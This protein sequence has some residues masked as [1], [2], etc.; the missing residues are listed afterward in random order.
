MVGMKLIDLTMETL[1]W[2]DVDTRTIG[3]HR[4]QKLLIAT[5]ELLAQM[6]QHHSLTA[7]MRPM[8]EPM[9]VKPRDW[10]TPTNGGYLSSYVRPIKL[11]K[12]TSKGYYEELSHTEMPVVYAAVN[13]MQSTAWAIN[14]PIL[15][16]LK[17]FWDRG[18]AVAGLPARMGQEI[19]SKPFD[20]ETNE[21]ARTAWR[22]AAA[23]VYQSNTEERSKR[24]NVVFTIDI[25]ER[26][27][28]YPSLYMPYQL[29]FRGRIYAVPAF[30]PQGPDHMKALLHF[31]NGKPLGANGAQW[32][33]MHGA[34]VAGNDKVS[35]EARVQWVLD[36]EQEI[37]TC[38]KNPLAERG[39]YTE[40]GGISI[41]KPWQFLAFC[42]EWAGYCV[43]GDAFVSR[44]AVALDGSC[45]G[46]Q[47][48][49]GMLRDEIGG[50]AVNLI[51]ADKPSDVYAMVADK[52]NSSLKA[53]IASG[54]SPNG[55]QEDVTFAAQWLEFGV[56]RKVTKRSVMT[57]AYGS[58]Q[59]G[60][61][62]QVLED[63]LKPAFRAHQ[64]SGLPFP[65]EGDGFKAASF[66]AAQIWE[67]V[68][69]TL[70]KSVEAMQ[71][72]QKAAVAVSDVGLPIR[73]S[74]PV[75]FPVMQAYWD[76]KSQ[77]VK[78]SLQGKILK[79][80]M[81]VHVDKLDRKSQ[82]NGIGANFI[83]S[84]DAAHMMLC[85]VRATQEGIHSFAMI[86]DSFGTLAADTEDLFRIV[87][88][89]FVEQY[90]EI[91]VLEEFRSEIL[92]QLGTDGGDELP[93]LPARGT[94]DLQGVL[95]S[96]FC[97]A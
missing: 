36:N 82:V 14:E 91:D 70:V 2:F 12:I 20:I 93:A 74:T 28:V 59:Y 13:A 26:Y 50:A 49:S 65:F 3:R 8:Y 73:W 5:P 66:M 55:K 81:G 27:K 53:I 18:H 64:K 34:N 24:L 10:S 35:L 29:D 44:L 31:S 22:H 63:T 19:P 30:N 89:S 84:C 96:R 52:V 95:D 51:A 16:V 80:T 38:G 88:E 92:R 54:C 56:T 76:I 4:T 25:S 15:A 7:T 21:D 57:L 33:A 39:W 90:E 85:T 68:T 77:I 61:K 78:T 17:E 71:W 48:Y 47:H 32:L 9:V 42:I 67:A 1:G 83:H 41:D 60:F 75:G 23:K 43:E 79:V 72:L 94:L 40:I 58:K 62:E 97:F 87:R 69:A 86:H 46:L 37:V 45:S 6:E 11:V